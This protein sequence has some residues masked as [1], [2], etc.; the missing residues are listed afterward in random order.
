MFGNH[1]DHRFE[2][3]ETVRHVKRDYAVGLHVFLVNLHRL[4]RNQMH[5]NRIAGK[6]IDGQHIKAL[7]RFGFQVQARI[8]QRNLDLRFSILE[9]AEIAMR[10][11][12][13][14]RIDI[15][16]PVDIAFIAIG[17]DGAGAE[18][19]DADLAR[20]ARCQFFLQ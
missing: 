20:L 8:A 14:I 13:D 7:R 12:D 1:I 4:E 10:D 5:R 18:T 3:E 2:I 16:E 9:I 15:V 6:G 11:S 17:G 19:N